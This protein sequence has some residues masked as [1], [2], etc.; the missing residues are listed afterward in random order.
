MPIREQT[1]LNLSTHGSHLKVC[2]NQF[3]V[4]FTFL[5]ER[6][7][8]PSESNGVIDSGSAEVRPEFEADGNILPLFSAPVS[9][10]FMYVVG[11]DSFA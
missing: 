1:F 9:V 6:D 2:C 11:C 5:H 7:T 4:S 8:R 3:H 10:V